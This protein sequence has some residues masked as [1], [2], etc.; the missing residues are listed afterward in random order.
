MVS[1]PPHWPNNQHILH[2]AISKA[3]QWVRAPIGLLLS[4]FPPPSGS[5]GTGLLFQHTVSNGRVP[6]LP[7]AILPSNRTANRVA[8]SPTST[9]AESCMALT[10]YNLPCMQHSWIPQSGGF[11]EWYFGIRSKNLNILYALL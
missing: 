8:L 3:L 5:L 6:P 9:C 2:S 11:P 1:D 10:I 4:L 7:W